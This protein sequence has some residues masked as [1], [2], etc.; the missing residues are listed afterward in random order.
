MN[1]VVLIQERNLEKAEALINKALAEGEAQGF[2]VALTNLT[3]LSTN[4]QITWR[5]VVLWTPKPLYVGD[6]PPE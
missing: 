3:P 1:K 6:G 2:Q 4:D 5:F